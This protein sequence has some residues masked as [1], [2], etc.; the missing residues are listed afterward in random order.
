MRPA[1]CYGPAMHP[2]FLVIGG[3][4]VGKSSTSRALAARFERS[5]HVPVD[6]LR[7]MVVG[8]LALPGP[9]WG[10]ELVRQVALARGMALAMAR[11]YEAAGFAVVLDDFWDRHGLLEYREAIE[12]GAL[13][14]VLLLPTQAEAHRRNAARSGADPVR[15]YLDEGIRDTYRQLVPIAADLARDGWLV[16]DSTDLDVAATVDAILRHARR[17]G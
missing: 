14:P 2:T 10:D 8:G 16:L 9:A 15:A 1:A 12:A 7:N 13:T 11:A 6:D 3:P 4:A 5:V 17:R